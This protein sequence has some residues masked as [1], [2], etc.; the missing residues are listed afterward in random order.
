MPQYSEMR[1]MQEPTPV[2]AIRRWP[3]L[4][5]LRAE[6]LEGESAVIDHKQASID[7]LPRSHE[8][9]VVRWQRPDGTPQQSTYRNRALALRKAQRLR[10]AGLAVGVYEASVSTWKAIPV[11]E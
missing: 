7:A 5:A 11:P 6:E 10:E 8:V 9:Q 4:R 2:G 3:V 1:R